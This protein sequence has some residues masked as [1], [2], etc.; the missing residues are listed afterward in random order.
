[1]ANDTVQTN[2]IRDWF[3]RSPK[4]QRAYRRLSA[5]LDALV[6]WLESATSG[7]RE[8]VGP[9]ID[10][11]RPEP[12]PDPIPDP[13]AEPGLTPD[14]QAALEASQSGAPKAEDTTPEPGSGGSAR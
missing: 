13:A 1:M 10:P 5:D 14:E 4:A 7:L 6:E 12:A 8:R 11:A 2:R 9:I 3:E